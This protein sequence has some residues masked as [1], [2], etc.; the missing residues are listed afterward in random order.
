MK[1]RI[2][3]S[4]KGVIKYIGH[5][6]LMRYF[7]KAFRRTDYKVSYSTGFSPHMIMSF[8]Q[9]LGVGVESEGEYF[10]VELEEGQD[11]TN[12]VAAL[13]E[14]MV[15]G[16]EVISY[17][18]LP[19]KAT[20]AMASVAASSYEID[21]YEG[22]P[23]SPEVIKKYEEKAEILYTKTTKSGETTF[24]IKEFVYNIEFVDKGVA[25]TIAASSSGNIKVVYLLEVLCNI[26]GVSLS[27]YKYHVLRKDLLLRNNAGELKPLNECDE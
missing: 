15:E 12:L 23:F 9:A 17:K 25:F 16:L 7:Q 5:L 2:K 21:F 24:N 6:D 3:F 27:D 10:D 11:L 13:N 4:K 26:A 20:N 14:Q 19:E 22:N 8:A 1:V 18:L